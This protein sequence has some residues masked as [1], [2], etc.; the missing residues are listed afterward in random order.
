MA[1]RTEV[2]QLPHY[3]LTADDRVSGAL[4]DLRAIQSLLK[5]AGA[6]GSTVEDILASA[7]DF[8]GVSELLGRSLDC[9][10]DRLCELGKM[11]LDHEKAQEPQKT[12]A[13][14]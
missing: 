5:L 11:I 4:G 1:A 6:S 13:A 2:P 7:G 9:L 12:K 10:T 14:A 8:Y 3:D